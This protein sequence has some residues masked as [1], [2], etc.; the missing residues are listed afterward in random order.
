MLTR[1]QASKSKSKSSLCVE[2]SPRLAAG[3]FKISV[4][5]PALNEAASIEGAVASAGPDTEVIVSDGGSTDGTRA[6]AARLGARVVISCPGRGAQ[7]D[8]GAAQAGGE[9]FLFLHAD[10]DR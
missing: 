7:M 6:I 8:A 10:T 3:S 5:I 9:V 4:I 2:D 1:G